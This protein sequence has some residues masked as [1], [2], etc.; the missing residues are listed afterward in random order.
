MVMPKPP[1]K[2]LIDAFY[3]KEYIGEN[4]WSEPE[5]ADSVLIE[6]C[7]IDRGAAYSSSASGKQLLYNAVVFCYEGMTTPIP[8]FKVQSVLH[9]DD[10]NHIVTKVI[11]IYE[12]YSTTIYS[13]ELEV[14]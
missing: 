9:F 1:Q 10:T 14:V 7:R 13:Y 12:A 2:F 6:H 3:Y 5:Y 4:D 11:P 8:K